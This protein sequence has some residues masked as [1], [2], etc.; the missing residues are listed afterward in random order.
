MAQA[1]RSTRAGAEEGEEEERGGKE[2][3]GREGAGGAGGRPAMAGGGGHRGCGGW[4]T[5][6]AG[7]N[8]EGTL[9]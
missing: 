6:E 4:K 1:P 5:G 9:T 8:R 3:M 2:E 7:K